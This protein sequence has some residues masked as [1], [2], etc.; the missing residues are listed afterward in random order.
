[1]T[2]PN[3]SKITNYFF[4]ARC[5]FCRPYQG[6]RVHGDVLL[7]VFSRAAPV[8]LQFEDHFHTEV[9]HLFAVLLLGLLVLFLQLDV[10]TA[11]KTSG[12]GKE[13]PDFIDEFWAK[14]DE[15]QG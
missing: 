4:P 15:K 5:N 2:E 10:R 3:S 6:E 7:R 9:H 8:L 1:M 14:F 12:G 11:S 13:V